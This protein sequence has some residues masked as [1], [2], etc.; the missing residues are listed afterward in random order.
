MSK[1]KAAPPD[2][3]S[4]RT[5]SN[6]GTTSHHKQNQL[7][8]LD[9]LISLL[10]GSGSDIPF[11]NGFWRHV[12]DD[13]G[14]NVVFYQFDHRAAVP[15]ITRSVRIV[16]ERSSSSRGGYLLLKPAICVGSQTMG[17]GFVSSV[18]GG[19]SHIDS[20]DD[21]RKLLDY[22]AQIREELLS[23]GGYQT[24]HADDALPLA[25]GLRYNDFFGMGQSREQ[26]G[27]QENGTFADGDATNDN[28]DLPLSSAASS[29]LID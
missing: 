23:G 14:K 7:L 15:R 10:H 16:Q 25:T 18:L 8:G 1:R 29:L 22:V 11:S 24:R 2:S 19:R 20:V 17:S 3:N 9:H 28:N 26:N 5:T 12:V 21:L 13:N 27:M 4:Q 6:K